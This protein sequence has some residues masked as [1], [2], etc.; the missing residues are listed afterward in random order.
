MVKEISM[1]YVHDFILCV[2]SISFFFLI[3]I[4]EI[5]TSHIH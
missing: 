4:R 3:S 5:W 2:A 1:L